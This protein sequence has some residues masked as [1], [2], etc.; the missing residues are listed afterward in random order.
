MSK[1]EKFYK[2]MHHKSK[3]GEPA[4][5]RYIEAEGE[6]W[7][8]NGFEFFI[9]EYNDYG[10]ACEE[11]RLNGDSYRATEGRSG[12]LI[13]NGHKSPDILKEH[14]KNA[15]DADY[16]SIVRNIEG[17]IKSHGASPLYNEKV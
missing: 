6:L 11:Y 14:V 7:S 12:L 16:D 3:K 8:Y 4:I 15:I 9:E 17:S 13:A 5:T 10:G 1:S 2:L